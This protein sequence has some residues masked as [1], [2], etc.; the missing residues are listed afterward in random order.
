MPRLTI[1]RERSCGF[2]GRVLLN[3][4]TEPLRGRKRGNGARCDRPTRPKETE[5]VRRA[6]ARRVARV[7]VRRNWLPATTGARQRPARISVEVN[8]R[9]GVE[10]VS[11]AR[12]ESHS[13]LRNVRRL[14][15]GRCNAVRSFKFIRLPRARSLFFL[16]A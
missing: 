12:R 11:R 7:C 5:T 2:F 1:A 14:S 10:C 16:F 15:K 13:S 9:D 8:K 6:A 4:Q 3:T